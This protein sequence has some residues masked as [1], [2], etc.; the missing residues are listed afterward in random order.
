MTANR[1]I[2]FA[3]PVPDHD[4]P[5]H[6]NSSGPLKISVPTINE[7]VPTIKEPTPNPP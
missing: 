3:V 5:P 1:A 7:A 4:M 2:Y 6:P